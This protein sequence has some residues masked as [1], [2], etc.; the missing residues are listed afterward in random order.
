[1]T[2]EELKDVIKLLITTLNDT[3]WDEGHPG[4]SDSEPGY[5]CPE[6]SCKECYRVSCQ[7]NESE[8]FKKLHKE[9]PELYENE[10]EVSE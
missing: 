7:F 1:M 8:L 2:K 4:Y 10:K 9:F 6:C 5:K 3:T